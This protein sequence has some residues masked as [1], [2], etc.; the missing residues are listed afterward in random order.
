MNL[1]HKSYYK[2][3]TTEHQAT[4]IKIPLLLQTHKWKNILCIFV[5]EQIINFIQ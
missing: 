3:K 4:Y 1:T 2:K 5:K